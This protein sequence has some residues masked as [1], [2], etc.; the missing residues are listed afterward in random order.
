MRTE[1]CCTTAP[2][3]GCTRLMVLLARLVRAPCAFARTPLDPI[4]PLPEGRA[5]HDRRTSVIEA[6]ANVAHD[7]ACA[8]E[9]VA[10]LRA[11]VLAA[12]PTTRQQHIAGSAV[13][14]KQDTL[15][16]AGVAVDRTCQYE[17]VTISSDVCHWLSR[18]F[19]PGVSQKNE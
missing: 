17:M 1:F 9:L 14:V 3:I 10:R 15:L 11:A 8:F 16:L 19:P 13:P 2:R 12:A 18:S 6:G 5:V 7:V 4:E